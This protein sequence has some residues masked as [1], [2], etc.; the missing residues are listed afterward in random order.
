MTRKTAALALLVLA[1][2]ASAPP[3]VQNPAAPEPGV[4][5]Q[6]EPGRDAATVAEMRAALPP[7]TPEILPG[8]DETVDHDRLIRQGYVRI[9]SA[10]FALAAAAARAAAERAGRAVG[11]DRLLLYAPPAG[12]PASAPPDEWLAVYYVRFQLPFGATFRDLRATERK[13]LGVDGGVAIGSVVSG[14]PA[15]RANLLAGDFVLKF[16]GRPIAGRSAFQTLLKG[17]AGHPVTLTIARNG[18]TL[19]RMVRLGVMPADR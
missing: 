1:G 9:G 17:R 13:K 4:R 7:A 6:S 3:S 14:T 15:S 10:R 19:Q 12:A 5:Y 18:E 2:C 8:K 11:A 16:D